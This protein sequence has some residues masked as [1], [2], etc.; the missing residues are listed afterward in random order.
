MLGVTALT[1]V[2]EVVDYSVQKERI[3]WE[4]VV[5][6]GGCL[7]SFRKSGATRLEGAI[8]ACRLVGPIMS[9]C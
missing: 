6:E 2:L 9:L 5:F 8:V 7:I 1:E 4:M 3:M